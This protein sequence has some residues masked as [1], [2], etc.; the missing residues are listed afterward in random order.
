[1][2]HLI[3]FLIALL[4]YSTASQAQYQEGLDSYFGNKGIVGIDDTKI[5]PIGFNNGVLQPDGKIVA[6]ANKHI[7]R[8]NPDGTLDKSFAVNGIFNQPLFFYYKGFYYA[9]DLY[10]ISNKIMLQPDGKII[11]MGYGWYPAPFKCALMIRL[12]P[13]GTLDPSFGNM[14]VVGDST[15]DQHEGWASALLLPDGK[16][17][18]VNNGLR[19]VRFKSNGNIDSSFGSNG[20]VIS[21]PSIRPKG[22]MELQ[23]DGKIL[24]LLDDFGVARY[25]PDGRPDSTFNKVGYNISFSGIGAPFSTAMALRPD[26]KIWMA[27]CTL[28]GDP[29][30]FILARFNA[31]G[32]I[33]STFNGDGFKDYATDTGDEN[34]LRDMLLL[35]DGKVVLGGRVMNRATKQDNFGLMRIHPDGREDSTFGING[36]LLTQMNLAATEGGADLNKLLLQTDN[37]LVALGSHGYRG[38]STGY[39]STVVRYYGNGKTNIFENSNNQKFTVFPNP[40]KDMVNIL[41]PNTARI[42][43]LSLSNI[44]GQ[45]VKTFSKAPISNIIDVSNLSNG[46]YF[47]GVKID[48]INKYQKLII[49]H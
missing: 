20:F 44:N 21:P 47:I 46:I 24:V 33:D 40:A 15:T 35:P 19:F 30:T 32:S 41:F 28:F 1:M 10:T 31:N 39:F 25:H 36:R 2:K 34:K 17:L 8:F 16:I 45:V 7:A 42:E 48:G 4:S 37:K 22:D 3:Y 18:A 6:V 9:Y 5:D 26:G 43:Y 14:G 12:M 49:Q 23:P 38:S 29:T 11:C 27:G 13:D